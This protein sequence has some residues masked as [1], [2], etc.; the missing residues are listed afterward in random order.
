MSETRP[1]DAYAV[2]RELDVTIALDS[3][4]RPPEWFG[5]QNTGSVSK[6]T[7]PSFKL[8]RVENK[9]HNFTNFGYQKY[10]QCGAAVVTR[11][12]LSQIFIKDFCGSSP[13][14]LFYISSCNYLCNIL[15]CVITAL[16]YNWLSIVLQSGTDK[17]W[18]CVFTKHSGHDFSYEQL[19]ECI[20]SVY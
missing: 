5:C 8:T 20:D 9:P 17:R 7:S 11:S 18:F 15:G 13:W 3:R 2:R 16:D 1:V 14:L 12:I 4:R 6:L 10:I 19:S